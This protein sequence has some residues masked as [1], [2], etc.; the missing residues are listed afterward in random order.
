MVWSCSVPHEWEYFQGCVYI[1]V[2]CSSILKHSQ[3]YLLLLCGFSVL[4]HCQER[5]ALESIRQQF[6]S[7]LHIAR[8]EVARAQH[9][10][11]E[12]EALVRAG[13]VQQQQQIRSTFEAAL[14]AAWEE[15]EQLRQEME[16]RTGLMAQE[17]DRW[18]Q[19]RARESRG[20]TCTAL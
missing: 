8:S 5:A 19:E 15:A 12:H 18:G 7:E 4:V 1:V 2:H 20:S 3:S 14:A 9:Q 10:S 17:I 13:E 11:E 16:H 6:E